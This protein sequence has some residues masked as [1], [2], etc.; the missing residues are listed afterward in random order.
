MFSIDSCSIS[1]NPARSWDTGRGWAFGFCQRKQRLY[2]KHLF[3]WN[4]LH[5][6][7]CSCWFVLYINARTKGGGGGAIKCCCAVIGWLMCAVNLPSFL[8]RAPGTA[9]ISVTSAAERYPPHCESC[10]GLNTQTHTIR[11]IKFNKMKYRNMWI[12][13]GAHSKGLTSQHLVTRHTRTND[14]WSHWCSIR[15]RGATF[16][17]RDAVMKSFCE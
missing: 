13:Y 14:V 10:L 3:F 17:L 11:L 6:G 2:T 4:R 12:K 7:I 8:H 15:A 1:Q 5:N 16:D 9:G